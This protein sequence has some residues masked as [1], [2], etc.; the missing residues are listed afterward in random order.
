MVLSVG[1]SVISKRNLQYHPLGVLIRARTP[2]TAPTSYRFPLEEDEPMTGP[3]ATIPRRSY[4]FLL[5]GTIGY[6]CFLFVWFSIAAFLTP[7]TN[8]LGLSS[9]AAGLLNGAVPLMYIPFALLSGLI[10]DR[11]GAYKAIGVGLLIVG[12][13]Q[14]GRGFAAGFPMMLALTLLLGLG[15]T[16]LTFGLPKLVSDLFPPERSGSM[17]SV[18]LIGLYAGTASAFG[19]GR[20]VLGPALGGWRPLFV[21]SGIVT[22][23]VAVGWIVLARL[24]DD[25][26]TLAP[27][28]PEATDGAGEQAFSL[29]SILSDVRRVITHR[30][31]QLL[32]VIGIMYL[33]VTHGLQGWLTV[34][35][36]GRGLTSTVAASITSGLIIAQLL[37]TV[38]LPPLSDYLG[39]RREVIAVCGLL[40]FAGTAGILLINRLTLATVLLTVGSVGIGIGGLATLV[41]SLPLNMDGIESKLA[42]TAVGLIFMVGEIGGFSGPFIVGFLEDLTGSFT[43]GLVLLSVSGLVVVLAA[44]P[45]QNVD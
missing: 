30:D 6:G 14:F 33:F 32:V 7:I 27:A 1:A 4:L 37:G 45:L 23:A 36:E 39:K 21:L 20:P 10:I 34:I 11:V 28:A 15:G 13:A 5:V 16:G 44:I 31:L 9:T 29:S 19:L 25:I 17:S 12:F 38:A 42:G 2:T 3:S 40:I 43:P 22:I 26:A 35:L 18:Y 24:S 8:Q 41:R